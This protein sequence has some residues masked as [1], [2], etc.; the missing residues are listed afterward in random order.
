MHL[1]VSQ[2][3]IPSAMKLKRASLEDSL[4]MIGTLPTYRTYSANRQNRTGVEV[5][6][7]LTVAISMYEARSV[8]RLP[9]AV[10]SMHSTLIRRQN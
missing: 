1:E 4:D 8:A 5:S 9:A 10:W 2:P 3:A 6:H 7:I